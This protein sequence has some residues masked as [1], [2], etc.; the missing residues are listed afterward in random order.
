MK[1]P[2]KDE[3][4]M[5]LRRVVSLNTRGFRLL[6]SLMPFGMVCR[7]LLAAASVFRDYFALFMSAR[8]VD[9]IIT[10]A[11]AERLM[12]L[13]VITV[14]VGLLNTC[15]MQ[16]L[17]WK[18]NIMSHQSWTRLRMLLLRAQTS[19]QYANLDS[20]VGVHLYTETT[21]DYGRGFGIISLYNE[22][23]TTAE[24]GFSLISSVALTVSLLRVTG[25]EGA[26]GLL[27]FIVS[28]W[29]VVVLALLVAG[30]MLLTACM[31][32]HETHVTAPLFDRDLTE[33][34]RAYGYINKCVPE[35]HIFGMKRL[36]LPRAGTFFRE[37]PL[38]RRALTIRFRYGF[39]PVLSDTLLTLYL[40]LFVAG[41][42]Y[43]GIFGIGSFVLYQGT[44][45][46]FTNAVYELAETVGSLRYNAP[47]LEKF[48]RF[49]DLPDVMY[50]GTL[51]VEKR[52]DRQ[53]EIEFRDVS[54]KYPGSD[55]WALRHVS[56]RFNVG[57]R[58]AL[59]GMNGSGK[60]TFVK[61]LC[62]LYDPTEGTILLNGIDVTKYRY[63]EY[64][65]LF[66]VVFQDFTLFAFT[67]GENVAM[68]VAPDKA[69]AEKCLSD[70]GLG[71]RYGEL[72]QGLDTHMTKN[73]DVSGVDFSQGE[74]QKLALAR[75]LYKDGAFLVL[76]EPTA[77]LDPLAEADVYARLGRIVTDRTAVFVSHRL[78]TCR[79]CDRILVFH[80]GEVVQAGTHDEL[81]R[82]EAGKY[83]ELW[84]AQAQY[85]TEDAV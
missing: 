58:L 22:S 72:A 43:L 6:F 85:Y 81:V 61:L 47:F 34:K 75:A 28:P 59:V 54:F 80:E 76:D 45:Q 63:E 37:R 18:Q 46:K 1:K 73:Y 13:A 4:K 10:R 20:P 27:A 84:H 42:A 30:N 71:E 48:F 65:A 2:E 41:K 52:D 82:D 11:G 17:S 62:R 26:T 15:L 74:C 8:M 24:A 56:M 64:M 21:G 69:R 53:F 3:T 38:W 33:S 39:V 66:S 50:K 16:Y 68:S 29:A 12:K 19:M 57:E 49:L 32:A 77:S 5:P 25:V 40:F 51:T 44:L 67:I 35:Y 55:K 23:W 79:F 36:G 70:V 78:S 60:S 9:A 31:S 83:Y 14:S 7:V